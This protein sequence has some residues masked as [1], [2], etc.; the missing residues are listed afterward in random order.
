MAATAMRFIFRGNAVGAGG[1]VNGPESLIISVQGASSLPVIGGYSR[2]SVGAVKFS[3]VLSL[4]SVRTEATGDFSQQENAYKTLANSVVKDIN[5]TGRLTADAM[6]ATFTSTHPASGGEPTIVP[7]GTQII[8]LR[9]DGYPVKVTLDLKMFTKYGTRESLSSAY[10]SDNAFY[11]KYGHRFLGPGAP[12]KKGTPAKRQIPES[13]GYIV[14]SIVSEIKTKHP[15]AVVDGHTITLNGFGIIFLG[16][17]LI[18]SASRRLT[19]L[20]VK[21]GSPPVKTVKRASASGAS[22]PY[23]GEI[24][25]ADVESNGGVIF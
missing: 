18:T 14:S 20:R 3:N 23:T 7:T 13:A 19:L 24:V 9:L 4:S 11:K 21:L 25:C 15:K 10:A 17:L 5:I 6:E 22:D 16:E 12:Q 1:Y 2:S 8:N